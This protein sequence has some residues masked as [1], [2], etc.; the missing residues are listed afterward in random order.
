MYG[1]NQSSNN[2]RRPRSASAGADFFHLSTTG[3]PPVGPGSATYPT[4]NLYPR[5]ATY[6]P[7]TGSNGYFGDYSY[8][9]SRPVNYRHSL[10]SSPSSSATTYSQNGPFDYRPAESQWPPP[11][12]QVYPDQMVQQQ[13][14]QMYPAQNSAQEMNT[15]GDA[16][17]RLNQPTASLTSPITTDPTMPR[18]NWMPTSGGNYTHQRPAP[19][20]TLPTPSNTHAG[21]FIQPGTSSPSHT[22]ANGM[23]PPPTPSPALGQYVPTTHT[24]PPRQQEEQNPAE[25]WSRSAYRSAGSI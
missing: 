15:G 23:P 17:W 3:P 5:S 1:L 6:P 20:V 2:Q 24:A 11:L 25:G 18:T 13:Q 19:P 14:Q 9:E 22:Y 7:Q 21:E 4:P 12:G 16:W 10:S 8:D